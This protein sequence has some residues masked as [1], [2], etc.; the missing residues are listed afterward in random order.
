MRSGRAALLV[1]A[2]ASLFATVGIAKGLGPDVPN[3]HLAC[4]R[5]LLAAGLLAVVA[6]GLRLDLFAS[7]PLLAAGLA[8]AVFQVGLFTAFSRVGVAVGTLV[9][10]G[11]SPLITGLLTRARGWRWLGSTAVAVIG[12]VLLVGT[13]GEPDPLGL[14]AAFVAAVALS[15]YIVAIGRPDDRSGTLP[16]RLTVIFGTGGLALVP[17]ALLAGPAGWA[18]VPSAW[19]LVL[20]VTVVPTVLAYLLYN[21]G[22]PHVGAPTTATLGLLEPVVA[23]I[24]GV[25]VLHETMS[26]VGALGAAF[27]VAAVLLLVTGGDPS[28][29]SGETVHRD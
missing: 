18:G 14:S 27:V 3:L 16:E 4:L 6:R 11:L 23:A 10:I 7:R 20:F 28:R 15:T 19:V 9:A 13:S 26:A 8:Q 22:S 12:L 21:A 2:G 24:L 17:V 1:A 29:R 25:T 5:L